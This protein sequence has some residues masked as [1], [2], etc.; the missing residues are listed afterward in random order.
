MRIAE[1]PTTPVA[2]GTILIHGLPVKVLFDTGAT[3]SFISDACVERL[4]LV[5]TEG[6]PFSIVLPDGSRVKG[7]REIYDCP[8]CVG[9]HVLLVDFF[10]MSLVHEDVI[11]GM[12]WMD[13]HHAVL[14]VGRRTVTVST[15]LGQIEVFRG[16]DLGKSGMVISAIRV[17]ILIA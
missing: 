17:A 10:V 12:D 5:T 4:S 2:T 9:T 13:R 16:W 15:E 14:D 1:E 6:I 11:L 7:T 8:I 3:H